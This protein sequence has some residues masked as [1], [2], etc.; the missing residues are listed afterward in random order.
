ML[1]D[2]GVDS[3]HHTDFYMATNFNFLS[4]TPSSTDI[5]KLNT[6]SRKYFNLAKDVEWLRV[7]SRTYKFIK[8]TYTNGFPHM[9]PGCILLTTTDGAD[10]C[11]NGAYAEIDVN[12][13]NRLPNKVGLDF[14]RISLNENG[15][16][17]SSSYYNG[18]VSTMASQCLNNGGGIG[19]DWCSQS[20]IKNNWEITYY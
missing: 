14:F 20:V 19:L 17:D 7:G 15:K 4:S 5:E 2:T 1:A 11:I 9:S 10:I 18:D 12:G 3:I 13:Y 6:L 16:V 8:L